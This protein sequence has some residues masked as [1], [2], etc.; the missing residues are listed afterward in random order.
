MAISKSTIQLFFFL[1]ST[2]LSVPG[3]CTT[4]VQHN[5]TQ[6]NFWYFLFDPGIKTSAKAVPAPVCTHS[7]LRVIASDSSRDHLCIYSTVKF[8]KTCFSLTDTNS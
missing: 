1:S 3:D 8:T 4:T 2:T 6:W 7:I 5:E